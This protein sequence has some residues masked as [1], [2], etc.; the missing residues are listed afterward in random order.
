LKSENNDS[1]SG[2]SGMVEFASRSSDD[3]LVHNLVYNPGKN[4]AIGFG[5]QEAAAPGPN[6]RG[7]IV[8]NRTTSID[9]GFLSSLNGDFIPYQSS[10]FGFKIIYP[11]KWKHIEDSNGVTFKPFISASVVLKPIFLTDRDPSLG[12]VSLSEIASK[13]VNIYGD[14]L[15]DFQPGPISSVNINGNAAE[16]FEYTGVNQGAHGKGLILVM[17]Q[18]DHYFVVSYLGIE[19]NYDILLPTVQKMIHSLQI[20]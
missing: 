3:S 9:Q 10:T 20:S 17:N 6:D 14:G 1:N 2:Q 11:S 15:T 5:I 12:P 13:L 7:Y 16:T 18:G 19:G 8:L 4:K